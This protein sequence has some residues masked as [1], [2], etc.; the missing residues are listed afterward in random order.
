MVGMAEIRRATLASALIVI[1]S[2]IP[3]C[4]PVGA[5]TG[6]A[7]RRWIT[8]LEPVRGAGRPMIEK[9]L[10]PSVGLR[11]GVICIDTP[12]NV[13]LRSEATKNLKSNSKTK[14]RTMC[15]H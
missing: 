13:F 6:A 12:C 3:V 7:P 9:V 2:G 4:L 11:A 5:H 10:M 1:P 8:S 15:P 14:L